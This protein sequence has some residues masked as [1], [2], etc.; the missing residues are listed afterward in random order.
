MLRP[1]VTAPETSDEQICAWLDA[2]GIPY[3]RFDHPPVF[4]CEEADR[5]VPAEA[6]GIQTKNLFLRDKPGRRHWLVVTTCE[7]PVDLR[8]LG[9][10]LDGGRLTFGSPERLMRYL[11]VTPGAVTLLALAHPG[12]RDVELVI[13]TDIWAGEPLRCHPMTNAA[14]LVLTRDSAERFIAA[15]GH[16]PR[17]LTLAAAP[18]AT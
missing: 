9:T 8:A 14:T 11:G 17:F 3:E 4:T 18:P 7:K 16:R 6:R 5:L 2:H 12:A 13:D 10:A 15:T 1:Y